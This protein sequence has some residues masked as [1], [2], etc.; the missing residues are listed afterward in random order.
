MSK[1]GGF[2]T[3][4]SALKRALVLAEKALDGA[5]IPGLKGAISGL[6]KIIEEVEVCAKIQFRLLS[7][8]P[9]MQRTKNNAQLSEALGVFLLGME[10]GLSNTLSTLPEKDTSGARLK[11][12][13]RYEQYVDVASSREVF[14]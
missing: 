10:E 4:K 7:S 9:S 6:L 2:D 13:T 11:A 5:P 3:A 12:V 1:P 14:D 8:L